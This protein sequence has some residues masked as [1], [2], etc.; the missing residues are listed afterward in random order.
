MK[1]RHAKPPFDS[2]LSYR[3]DSDPRVSPFA[4]Q[5]PRNAHSLML[6]EPSILHRHYFLYWEK[7]LAGLVLTI[8][9]IRPASAIYL[10]KLQPYNGLINFLLLFYKIVA[11]WII[12]YE[13]FQSSMHADGRSNECYTRNEGRIYLPEATEVAGN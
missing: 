1:H 2:E 11:F 4:T 7:G 3:E 13:A 8:N 9:V 5:P 10:Q 6:Y 12:C